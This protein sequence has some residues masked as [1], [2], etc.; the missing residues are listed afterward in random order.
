MRYTPLAR[1]WFSPG[2]R[3]LPPLIAAGWFPLRWSEKFLQETKSRAGQHWLPA[4]DS[5]T[6][7]F[8]GLTV[9]PNILSMHPSQFLPT[10]KEE[11]DQIAWVLR[12]RVCPIAF[13]S[14]I[15][16]GGTVYVTED[17]QYFAANTGE[18]IYLGNT[19]RQLLQT[20]VLYHDAPTLTGLRAGAVSIFN[21]SQSLSD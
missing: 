9:G 8:G 11:S 18:I 16:Q 14:Y 10:E 2:M 17:G 3:L 6:G 5:F 13:T 1:G 4:A 21:H 7:R 12:V 19:L 20:L 15:G